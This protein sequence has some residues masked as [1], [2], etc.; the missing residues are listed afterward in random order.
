[1]IA[2]L[3]AN[4]CVCDR[5]HLAVMVIEER[6]FKAKALLDGPLLLPYQL[7]PDGDGPTPLGELQRVALKVKQDLLQPLH[8]SLDFKSRIRKIYILCFDS[9]VLEIG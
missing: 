2:F 1:L 4:A 6:L 9:D 3:D 5:D 7:G 8:V